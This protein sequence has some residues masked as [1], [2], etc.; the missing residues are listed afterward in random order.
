[1]LSLDLGENQG[2]VTQPLLPSTAT[3]AAEK[4]VL[5]YREPLHWVMLDEYKPT[6]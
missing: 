6:G 3:V 4:A 2:V 1:M 5:L